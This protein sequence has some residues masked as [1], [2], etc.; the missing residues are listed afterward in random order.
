MTVNNPLEG[1]GVNSP[2]QLKLAEEA[3]A[4]VV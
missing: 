4:S 2:E 1:I 3:L